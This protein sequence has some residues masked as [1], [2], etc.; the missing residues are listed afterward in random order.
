MLDAISPD[1]KWFC[2][3]QTKVFYEMIASEEIRIPKN[4]PA[5]YSKDASLLNEFIGAIQY[6]KKIHQAQLI[7]SEELLVLARKLMENIKKEYHLE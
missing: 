7:R 3:F 2:P 6:F 4:N 5:L 1:S